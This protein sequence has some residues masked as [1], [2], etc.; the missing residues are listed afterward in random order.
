MPRR[1]DP[2]HVRT[3]SAVDDRG[4][5]YRTTPQILKTLRSAWR[6][7]LPLRKRSSRCC[8]TR[9]RPVVVQGPPA[10]QTET[11]SD[12]VIVRQ[13]CTGRV[14]V[15]LLA[16]GNVTLLL[17]SRA[18]ARRQ[19]M[20]VRISLGASRSRPLRMLLTEGAMFSAAAMAPALLLA[21]KIPVIMRA[22]ATTGGG[23][24]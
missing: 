22:T 21:Y 16:R 24:R 15:C 12:P 4:K 20:A 18:A 11:S 7:A 13:K 23:L 8:S 10:L 1:L 14:S 9:A 17:L 5:W 19:E 3:L 6:T 2:F